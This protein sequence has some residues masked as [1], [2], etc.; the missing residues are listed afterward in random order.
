MN[1]RGRKG[2]FTLIEVML[3]LMILV[4]LAGLAVFAFSGRETAAKTDM[5]T[6][7]IKKLG[8]FL[9]EYKVRIG[10]YPTEEEGGLQALVTRPQFED[11]K[12][13]ARWYRLAEA[14]QIKDAWDKPLKYEVVKNESGQDEARLTSNGPDGEEGTDDDIKSWSED[15][16]S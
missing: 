15:E 2:G 3:V 12:V 11:E 5:T 8:G 7:I 9:D 16:S 4:G 14:S 10:H 1:S 13:G 6:F